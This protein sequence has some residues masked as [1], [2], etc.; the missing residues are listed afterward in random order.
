MP[1]HVHQSRSGKDIP[2]GKMEALFRSCHI[3]LEAQL[4]HSPC[5][6]CGELVACH[7][8]SSIVRD[9]QEL[10]IEQ[11]SALKAA[12][13]RMGE[14]GQLRGSC[15][16]ISSMHLSPGPLGRSV[17]AAQPQQ[18][19]L[20]GRKLMGKVTNLHLHARREAQLLPASGTTEGALRS[21]R[22]AT[23]NSGLSPLMGT[24]RDVACNITLGL[25]GCHCCWRPVT[26]RS[27]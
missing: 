4:V 27:D 6:F 3:S 14:A 18:Q 12:F 19:R 1:K 2:N 22:Q 7:H 16:L 20:Q 15:A 26:A 21:K 11:D 10:G 23:T 8:C 25:I 17:D 13:S 9:G 24:G 5:T